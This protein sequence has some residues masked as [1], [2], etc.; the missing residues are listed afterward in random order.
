ME[1]LNSPEILKLQELM[2]NH[3]EPYYN[4]YTKDVMHS[5]DFMRFCLDFELSSSIV[6]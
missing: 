5:A 1:L 6:S 4:Y 3:F 2:Y